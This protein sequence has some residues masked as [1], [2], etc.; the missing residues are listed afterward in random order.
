MAC[1]QRGVGTRKLA[2]IESSHDFPAPVGLQTADE[3]IVLGINRHATRAHCIFDIPTLLVLRKPL[4]Q[5]D[6]PRIARSRIAPVNSSSRCFAVD[7]VGNG[8][9]DH[10][11]VLLSES[12]V[13]SQMRSN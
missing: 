4:D 8:S 13:N 2:R 3:V 5:F 9:T 11:E 12:D 1:R 7:L 6:R 10:V